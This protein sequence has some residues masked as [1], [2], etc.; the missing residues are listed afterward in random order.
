VRFDSWR[1]SLLTAGWVGIGGIARFAASVVSGVVFFGADAPAGQPV[2]V[3]SLLYNS[4]YLLPS[5][6]VTGVLTAV[7]VPVLTRAVPVGTAWAAKT[8]D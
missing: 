3:Y 8:V 2:L 4:S 1:V 7:I 5:L 6:V